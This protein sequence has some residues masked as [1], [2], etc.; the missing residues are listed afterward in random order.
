MALSLVFAAS[1]A[2]LCPPAMGADEPAG[3]APAEPSPVDDPEATESEVLTVVSKGAAPHAVLRLAVQ[4]SVTV[5]TA[6]QTMHN[7]IEILESDGTS[8]NALSAVESTVQ[9]ERAIG[10]LPNDQMVRHHKLSVVDLRA[11]RPSGLPPFIDRAD[12]R[13]RIF[14]GLQQPSWSD[15]YA[16]DGTRIERRWNG[17]EEPFGFSMVAGQFE[18]VDVDSAFPDVAVGPGA[19]WTIVGEHS[20]DRGGTMRDRETVTLVSIDDHRVT[21][22]IKGTSEQLRPATMRTPAG[23]GIVEDESSRWTIRV[24]I[25]LHTGQQTGVDQTEN[26]IAWPYGDAPDAQ[27]LR[28]SSHLKTVVR[29]GAGDSAEPKAAPA[30]PAEAVPSGPV[31]AMA[32]HGRE[33]PFPANAYVRTAGQVAAHVSPDDLMV[34]TQPGG[35]LQVAFVSASDEGLS[36]AVRATFGEGPDGPWRVL[37]GDLSVPLPDDTFA[38]M[39]SG[40]PSTR[41]LPIGFI[42][43]I[44]A[45]DSLTI[46]GPW[47]APPSSGRFLHR[48]MKVVW[49]DAESLAVTYR[50]S[51]TK[52]RQEMWWVD[53]GAQTYVVV[54]RFEDGGAGLG[55]AVDAVVRGMAPR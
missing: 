46:R 20:N 49:K 30:P 35:E 18:L 21:L 10:R 51:G 6:V 44:D 29:P 17:G 19:Q 52:W 24:T 36:E 28:T 43:D 33:I 25:D 39:W 34:L 4:P 47:D 38:Y 13:L 9:L 22:D 48:K 12:S 16:A 37:V 55:D 26:F 3:G 11:G 41:T 27:R 1:L 8:T 50:A 7:S 32:G 42:G 31:V 40:D 23:P 5:T 14:A 15:T 45:K 54:H 2:L 53:V